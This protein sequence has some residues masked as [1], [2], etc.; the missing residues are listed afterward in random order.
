[1]CQ[2]CAFAPFIYYLLFI[3]KKLYITFGDVFLL[4]T[5]LCNFLIL[6]SSMILF[7][8]IVQLKLCSK[9]SNSYLLHD[10]SGEV[11]VDTS[12]ATTKGVIFL[13]TSLSRKTCRGKLFREETASARMHRCAGVPFCLTVCP[14]CSFLHN[15]LPP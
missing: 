12:T 2:G 8:P 11:T 4:P 15:L 10:A 1:V 5:S 14:H 7:G 6:F 9:L 3:K 13:L